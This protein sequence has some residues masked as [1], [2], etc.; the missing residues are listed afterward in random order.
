MKWKVCKISC[1]EHTVL[2][3]N[4]Y[5]PDLVAMLM[6]PISFANRALQDMAEGLVCSANVAISTHYCSII[7]NFLRTSLKLPLVSDKD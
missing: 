7:Y 5:C 1:K 2:Q 3:T 4:S 6:D